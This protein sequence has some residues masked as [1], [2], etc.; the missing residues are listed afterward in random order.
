MRS[1]TKENE[2]RFGDKLFPKND[3]RKKSQLHSS[4]HVRKQSHKSMN[5]VSSKISFSYFWKIADWNDHSI[6]WF[7]KN[8]STCYLKT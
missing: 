6:R 3:I 5:F 7:G 1:K 4:L 8:K 2:R